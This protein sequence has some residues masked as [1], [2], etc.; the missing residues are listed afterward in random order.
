LCHPVGDTGSYPM[1][2]WHILEPSLR[3]KSQTDLAWAGIIMFY[4]TTRSGHNRRNDCRGNQTLARRMVVA[5]TLKNEWELILSEG[6]HITLQG[7]K[8]HIPGRGA[9]RFSHHSTASLLLKP[10]PSYMAIAGRFLLSMV[11]P[12]VVMP[13]P[14]R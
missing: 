3:Y 1:E 7:P 11:R 10:R 9:K 5:K 8:G 6:A 2:R 12:T 4:L 13:K 14:I